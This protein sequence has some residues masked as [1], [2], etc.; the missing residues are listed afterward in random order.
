MDDIFKYLG[1][2]ILYIFTVECCFLDSDYSP[3]DY[4]IKCKVENTLIL[5]SNL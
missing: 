5:P 2:Y 4:K 1:F 3:Q